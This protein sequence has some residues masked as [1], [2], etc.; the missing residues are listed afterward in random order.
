MIQLVDLYDSVK[1]I[2]DEISSEF[3]NL[4]F[5]YAGL[6]PPYRFTDIVYDCTPKNTKVIA[7]TGG[8]GVHFSILELSGIVQPVII[9]A[10]MNAGEKIQ[11]NSKVIAENLL[12][13]L[14]LGFY[15]GWFSLEQLFYDEKSTL[16]FYSSE[17]KED[18]FQSNAD[19]IFLKRLRE[20][21]QYSFLPLER[22]RLLKLE[23]TYSKYLIFE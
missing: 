3:P 21:F 19:I 12:E 20:K 9:S 7:Y 8:N 4:F 5:D 18:F 2:S 11:D 15:N 1:L 22:E 23:S 13:F 16:D 17:N 10:P 14:S 6:I